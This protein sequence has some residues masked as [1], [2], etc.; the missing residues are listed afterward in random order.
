MER[1]GEEGGF[2][3]NFRQSLF[4]SAPKNFVGETFS[5]SLISGIEKGHACEGYVT[6]FWRNFL[7]LTIEKLRRGALLCFTKFLVSKKIMEEKGGRNVGGVSRFSV[8]IFLSQC[9]KNL[10]GNP[11]MCH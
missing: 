6:Y 8:K 4:V 10:L 9:R 3:K 11:L 1:R 2:I 5:V 7:S